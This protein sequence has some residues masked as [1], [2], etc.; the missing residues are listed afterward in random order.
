M[1]IKVKGKDPK[2]PKPTTTTTTTP[3]PVTTTPAPPASAAKLGSYGNTSIDQ[4]DEAFRWGS[5][6]V[7]ERRGV[8]V[9]PR[10]LKA[11]MDVETGGDGNYPPTKC[12]PSDGFDNVPACGPMQ[13]K[14]QYHKDR[15][16]ECNSK[17]VA[18]Q[19]E[20]AAHIIGMTMLE[21]KRDEYDAITAV[22][23]PG[24]DT[25]GTTQAGYLKRV[26]SL[27]KQ[28]EQDANGTTPAVTTTPAPAPQKKVTEQDVLNLI[29]SKTPGVYVSFPFL[30]LNTDG[31]GNPVNI[32][33]YGKG[34][35]TTANNMHPG[36][37]IWMPDETPVNAVFGGEVICVGTQGEAVWGQG[38][39]YFSDDNGGIGKIS[40]LTDRSV[41]VAGK[42]RRMMMVYG[43]MSASYVR[44]GERIVDGQRIGR[45]GIGATWPHVHLDVGVKA[46]ELNNPAIWNNP[47]E[48][49]LLDP[50]PAI[51]AAYRGE[52]PVI[53]AQRLE[54][55]QPQE[56]DVSATVRATKDGVP[57]LQRA[58]MT[59]EPV[60]EPLK[61]GEEFEA[62]YQ[63][64][65]NDKRIYWVSSLGS[66]IP[67]DGTESDE[68][69]A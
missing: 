57:V 39:G 40:V 13:I 30:G 28:M 34:H 14:W 6:S 17:T 58:M 62:V 31:N 23:F 63:V 69:V 64:I 46:P 26:R 38:C 19:V 22:Y 49:H 37:D 24:A 20:M 7:R 48:Y 12:R 61:K 1:P 4:W 32:Y 52:A 8:R 68:W 44:P 5:Q 2:P 43:H 54:I 10:V 29:S 33:A 66:R 41:L 11:M 3:A 42:E 36:I 35:G 47:G 45:S 25:N 59:A 16:P 18:G 60:R 50:L 21:R 65:G 27:V 53:Y 55:P 9:D 51:V 56:F 67:V 15:C